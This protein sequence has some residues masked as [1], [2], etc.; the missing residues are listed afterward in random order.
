MITSDLHFMKEAATH[1]KDPERFAKDFEQFEHPRHHVRISKPFYLGAFEVTQAEYEQ[2]ASWK[3]TAATA[4]A[5]VAKGG[6][7]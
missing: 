4:D 1:E 5:A 2:A 6:E 7:A 3:I